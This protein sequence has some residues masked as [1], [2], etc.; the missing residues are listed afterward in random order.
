M[1]AD[2]D[3]W[4]FRTTGRQEAHPREMIINRYMKEGSALAGMLTLAAG[5]LTSAAGMLTSAAGMLTLA[6][7]AAADLAYR[8]WSVLYCESQILQ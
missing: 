1:D 8:L 7:S 6:A 2:V 3:A 5:M 4:S